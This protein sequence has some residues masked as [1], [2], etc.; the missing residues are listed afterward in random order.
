MLDARDRDQAAK[1][2]RQGR[3]AT[4]IFLGGI[5]AVAIWFGIVVIRNDAA[6][7][8][9]PAPAEKP[10]SP[11]AQDANSDG[12]PGLGDLKLEKSDLKFAHDLKDFIA[13]DAPK[14]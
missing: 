10:V 13:P 14:K 9:D 11:P 12:M 8:S 6:N 5:L 7:A 1:L 3:Y 4:P 2:R